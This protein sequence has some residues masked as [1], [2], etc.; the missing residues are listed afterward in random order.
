MR[1]RLDRVLV[2]GDAQARP[3][4]R[5]EEASDDR[6]RIDDDV[7]RVAERSDE[8]ALVGEVADRDA[9]MRSGRR[10]EPQLALAPD[11]NRQP[12]RLGGGEH[13]VR[14]D[15]PAGPADVDV[16]DVGCAAADELADVAEGGARFVRQQRHVEA[17]A[18]KREL[19][20]IPSRERLLDQ[21]QPVL[22]ERP[23][24]AEGLERARVGAVGVDL[25]LDLVADGLPDGCD[26]LAVDRPGRPTF[27]LTV[28]KPSPTADAA[29]SAVSPGSP[30]DRPRHRHGLARP[31]AEQLVRGDAER[32]TREIEE[33]IVETG[34]GRL[35]ALQRAFEPDTQS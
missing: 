27:S 13:L 1:R 34:L 23:Q 16:E 26:S 5:L 11:Q 35:R 8:V 7:A 24:R 3:R 9:E 31:A 32:L 15:Q 6:R 2:D 4:R 33:S 25:D 22:L 10:A 19:V 21:L 29:R 30:R 14:A 18:K 12:R 28:R 17:R 20:E